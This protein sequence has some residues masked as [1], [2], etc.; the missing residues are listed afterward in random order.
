MELNLR[1]RLALLDILPEK[2]GPTNL[3][4]IR[5]LREA[6]SLTEE[7]YKALSVE[8]EWRCVRCPYSKLLIAKDCPKCP[9]CGAEMRPTSRIEWS[10]QA[11]AQL[12]SKEIEI[13]EIMTG[14]IE[15]SF[16]DLA[17]AENL[18]AGQ[19]PLYK[20]FLGDNDPSK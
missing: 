11:E 1:E 5:K 19:L 8:F 16:R 7:E 6:L 3:A 10:S 4:I 15:R 20:R 2:G 14:I 12:G 18:S 9:E 13:G 17:R